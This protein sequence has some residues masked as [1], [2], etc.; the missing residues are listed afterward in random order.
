MPK[1]QKK[2]SAQ[3]PLK[4]IELLAEKALA[5]SKKKL[6]ENDVDAREEDSQSSSNIGTLKNSEIENNVDDEFD[7][8]IVYYQ[9]NKP[10]TTAKSDIQSL[11][12]PFFSLAKAPDKV[13]RV[14]EYEVRENGK[15]KQ[16][17][18][19]IT[20]D[21]EKEY[22]RPT[23]Y[24]KDII[25]YCGS[26]IIQAINNGETP[27]PRV[28]FTAYR[29]LLDTKRVKKG[30]HIGGSYYKAVIDQ[31]ERLN[32]AR[33]ITNIPSNG[34]I[35]VDAFYYIDKY[36]L[37]KDEKTKRLE[38][39]EVVLCDFFYDAIINKQILTLS[40]RYYEIETPIERKLYGFARKHVG[41]QKRKIEFF[42]ESLYKKSGSTAPLK[43]FMRG[44]R[45][46]IQ[47]NR[48]PDYALYENKTT[49]KIG[50]FL[51]SNNSP[52]SGLVQ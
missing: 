20:P 29:Y 36:S 44:V 9:S 46:A 10:C 37:I 34:K 8:E 42:Y 45:K 41:N 24:D 16:V 3:D 11:E 39:I 17:S 50:F 12:H 2:A 18:I 52:N 43:E 27:S 22:G 5:K 51:R 26:L 49:K 21:P 33:V 28:R 40:P 4:Q 1:Q 15:K 32:R 25:T 6:N 30:E 13:T 31:L 14:F 47:H 48:L 7:N 23:I 38:M 35:R 19:K